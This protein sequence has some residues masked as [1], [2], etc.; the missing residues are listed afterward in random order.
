MK[1]TKIIMAFLVTVILLAGMFTGCGNTHD[2][3][4]TGAAAGF[5]KTG[6]FPAAEDP[7]ALRQKVLHRKQFL[8][9]KKS[10]HH[11]TIYQ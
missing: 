2:Q 3:E 4:A 1:N 5:R 7:F 8:G 9:R 10:D 11:Y 6:C